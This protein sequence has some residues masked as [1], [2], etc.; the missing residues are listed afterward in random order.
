MKALMA[1][2]SIIHYPCVESYVISSKMQ[3]RMMTPLHC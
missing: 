3:V 2:S 1:S